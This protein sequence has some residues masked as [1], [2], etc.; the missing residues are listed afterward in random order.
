MVSDI[1]WGIL[2]SFLSLGMLALGL[3]IGQ[4]HGYYGRLDEELDEA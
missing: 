1:A 3:A 2:A 4:I